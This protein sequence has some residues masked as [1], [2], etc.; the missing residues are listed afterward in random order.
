M[1]ICKTCGKQFPP[2]YDKKRKQEYCSKSCARTKIDKPI[3]EEI[4]DLLN[5]NQ[6][7]KITAELLGIS[8][9]SLYNWIET[10]EIKKVILYR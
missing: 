3:R 10:Y 5:R 6:D 4:V 2:P 8:R 1:P 9:D 7:I